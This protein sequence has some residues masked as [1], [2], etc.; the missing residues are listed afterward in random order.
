VPPSFFTSLGITIPQDRESL[1]ARI[2]PVLAREKNE[3]K[4]IVV[5]SRSQEKPSLP[6]NIRL[7]GPA[8]AEWTCESAW[9]D[10]TQRLEMELEEK[11]LRY[12]L[13]LKDRPKLEW[14]W[15]EVPNRGGVEC[16]ILAHIDTGSSALSIQNKR[17]LRWKA[18][19]LI[20]G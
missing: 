2:W 11:F 20:Q 7:T 5:H 19:E 1:R 4:E 14:S 6:A 10:L 3:R 8:E 9:A 13:T 16:T 18:M 15:Q 12:K 17:N